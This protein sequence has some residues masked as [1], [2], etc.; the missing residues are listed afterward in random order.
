MAQAAIQVTGIKEVDAAFAQLE[1]KLQ[2]KIQRKALRQAARPILDD[3]KSRVSHLAERL[4]RTLK[5]RALKT[6]RR[7]G[8]VGVRVA[9]TIT[10]YTDEGGVFNP[11]WVEFGIPGHQWWGRPGVPLEARPFL[12]PAMDAQKNTVLAIF[13]STVTRLVDETAREV[14]KN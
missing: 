2:R 14:R 5:L 6:G 11:H 8:I 4:E 7:S 13:K 12:R 9:T 10:E 1:P 3:A